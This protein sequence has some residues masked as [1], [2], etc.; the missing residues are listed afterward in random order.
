MKATHSG[1]L[2][3]HVSIGSDA[4]YLEAKLHMLEHVVTSR[5]VRCCRNSALATHDEEERHWFYEMTTGQHVFEVICCTQGSY[6]A[7][8]R[9]AWKR[10]LRNQRKNRIRKLKR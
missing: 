7:R 3:K 10:R 4:T 1:A 6:W 9:T 5:C 8:W 2:P